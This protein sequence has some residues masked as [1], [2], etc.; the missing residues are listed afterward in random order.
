MTQA[1]GQGVFAQ[2]RDTNTIWA[3]GRQGLRDKQTWSTGVSTNASGIRDTDMYVERV[4]LGTVG[5]QVEYA[6]VQQ[7]GDDVTLLSK[8][9]G[10][11]Q[12]MGKLPIG[13][14]GGGG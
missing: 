8:V 13:G 6:F 7:T 11:F 5:K 9:S 4:S 3:V 12:V 2:D 1:V 14:S 10:E